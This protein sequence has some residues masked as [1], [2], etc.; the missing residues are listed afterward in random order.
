MKDDAIK[1][2]HERLIRVLHY[3]DA[4]LD[5]DLSVETLSGVAAFSKFHFHRQFSHLFG[6]SVYA[7][8]QA[9]RLKR[10][11]YQLAFRE[12]SVTDIALASGYDAPEAFSRAFK[13]HTGQLP[14]DFRKNPGFAAW[15]ETYNPIQKLRSHH[16]QE[17][18]Y[19][20]QVS[21]VDVPETRI[22][23]LTHRG[24]AALLGETLRKFI[25]WR[26]AVGLHPKNHATYTLLYNDP[27]KVA[28]EDFRVDLCV[29]TNADIAPNDMG[30]V[31]RVIPAGRCALLRQVGSDDGFAS[32]I[33]YLYRNW[34][35]QSGEELRDFP[36]YC[37]RVTLYPDVPEHEMIKDIYLPLK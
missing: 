32:A 18:N 37:Q 14:S 10:A 30:I 22:A 35:P 21:V 19:D 34:L 17:Q 25:D 31:P 9:M 29:A 2:Y 36:L 5:D 7:Y 16:M 13:K 6:I 26:K 23:V 15:Q 11:S 12:D 8:V 3:I 28:P 1:A 33:Y 24:D 27:E 20:G 4:H